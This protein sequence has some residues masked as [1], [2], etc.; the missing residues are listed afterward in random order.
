[1]L[2]NETHFHLQSWSPDG[3]LIAYERAGS[4]GQYEIWMLP[5]EGDRKPYSYLA[6]QFRLNQ[7]A[8]S[9]DGHWLAYTSNESGRGEVYVQR[10]PGPGEKIQVSTDGGSNPEWTHDGKQLVYENA[11]TLWAVEVSVSPFRVGKSRVLYQGDIWND[12]AGPNYTL[13]PT[14]KRIVA[15]ERVKDP[16]GGNVKVIL[17]WSQ[18]L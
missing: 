1:L 12:A 18:E 17:N 7:P 13:A 15:V 5:L 6:S 9:M 4:S 16:E 8:F 2:K 3:K 10:F 14:G 11:G